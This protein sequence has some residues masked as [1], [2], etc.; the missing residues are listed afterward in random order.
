MEYWASGR[1]TPIQHSITPFLHDVGRERLSGRRYL[2]H[3]PMDQLIGCHFLRQ[4]LK[5]QHDAVT[6]YVRDEIGD[7]LG[8][9]VSAPAQKRQRAGP[10]NEIDR[11]AGACAEGYIGSD[12][13]D[14]VALRMS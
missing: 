7:V 9:H 11:G 4:R 13:G 3:D 1:S 8:Q 10:L 12:V 6:K 14:A 5:R 2:L